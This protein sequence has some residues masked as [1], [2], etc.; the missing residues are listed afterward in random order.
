MAMSSP[1]IPE[2]QALKDKIK[3]AIER[4]SRQV[5]EQFRDAVPYRLKLQNLK[6]L[7]AKRSNI[8]IQFSSLELSWET[9]F[10]IFEDLKISISVKLEVDV[11][12]SS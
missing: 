7:K 4:S 3:L 9:F 11:E 6:M 5:I 12:D 1:N 10:L 8:I 2:S